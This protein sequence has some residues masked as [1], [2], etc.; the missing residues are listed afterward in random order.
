M[1]FLYFRSQATT[2]LLDRDSKI[3]IQNLASLASGRS[4]FCLLLLLWL[5]GFVSND[6]LAVQ[7]AADCGFQT[8]A[9]SYYG[10]ATTGSYLADHFS[11]AFPT[12]LIAGCSGGRT[13]RITSA[14]AVANFL[15]SPVG[16]TEVLDANYLNPIKPRSNGTNVYAS[17]FAGQVVVLTLSVGFDLA[18]A[19]YSSANVPLKDAVITSGVFSGKTVNFVLNQA[20]LVLGGCTSQYSLEQLT[21]IITAINESYDNGKSSDLLTCQATCNVPL[22]VV[23]EPV[24]Y[25]IGSA[26]SPLSNSVTLAAGATLQ[27][28]TTAAGGTSLASN[29]QPSTSAI[30]STT[31]YLAQAIGDCE[32]NRV[33]VVVSIVTKPSAPTIVPSL[34]ANTSNV[35]AWGDSFTDSNF[36]R[37]P[38][39]LSKLSGYNVVNLGV[40]GQNST[41]VKTRM[42][43][44]AQKR[45]W[46][47]IIWAGRNDSRDQIAQT[48]ANIASMVANL[49]HTNYLVISVFN[50]E[51]EGKGTYAYS[52]IKTLNSDLAKT[53]GTH[54]LDV[55]SYM[56]SQYNTSSAQDA[57]FYTADIPPASLRQDFLHPNTAGSDV[58]ANYIYAH[59]NQLVIGGVVVQYCQGEQPAPLSSAFNTPSTGATLRFYDSPTATTPVGSGNSYA[60]ATSTGGT[61]LFYVSQAVGTCESTRTP[62]MVSVNDCD[63]MARAGAGT[64]TDVVYMSVY[65]NPFDTQAIVGVQ[66]P[67]GQSYSLE[68]Y[69]ATGALV[70]H[71]A[72]ATA[73]ATEQTYSINSI[74]LTAGLYIVRLNAGHSSQSFRLT[75]I[76]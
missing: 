34:T 71:L 28:Y 33:P 16:T 8:H 73:T 72:T 11:A 55:R 24:A 48:E 43:A 38:A 37:Y 53:Y 9:Q 1:V 23:A 44:D 47:A 32:S 66:L 49:T 31:Y 19:S 41:Q 70:Q 65:P 10:T 27:I 46:P 39:T 42:L 6:A 45:T 14:A 12:G 5:V 75:L 67:T 52:Q 62:I 4:S 59:L 35:A 30:S 69:N 13:L 25:C 60:P 17:N 3:S 40:G 58:I 29:F 22:P 50:G 18:D 26:T 20:N 51:G 21:T 63:A 54:Y 57:A 76:K 56:V 36:G 68:L 61:S 64:S 2:L 15:P 7:A 74:S